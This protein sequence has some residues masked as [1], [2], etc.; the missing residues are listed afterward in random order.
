MRGRMART[1][2]N[3][4]DKGRNRRYEAAHGFAA[5]VQ[6]YLAD[7]PVQAC[8]PSA[9]YRL[10]KF[11]RRNRAALVTASAFVVAALLAVGSVGWIVRDRANRQAEA[12]HE[13]LQRQGRLS[14]RVDQILADV[15]R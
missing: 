2:K 10:R 15:E 7:E 9:W 12:E 6:R 1:V 4:V 14:T 13:R 8:P 5:D 3:S 11:A